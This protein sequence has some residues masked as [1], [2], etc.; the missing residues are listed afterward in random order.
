MGYMFLQR[1][2]VAQTLV[3]AGYDDFFIGYRPESQRY[4]DFHHSA[5][6]NIN[7]IHPRSLEM[8]AASMSAL[9]Y[10]LDHLE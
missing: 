7:A 1:A 6:D 3:F 9:F 2:E 8:G 10:L 5:R 4:F